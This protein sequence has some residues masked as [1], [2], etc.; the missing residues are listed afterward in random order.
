MLYL[1]GMVVGISGNVVIQST[2]TA[3]DPLASVSASTMLLAVAAIVWLATV[4]GDVAHGVVMFPVLRA[5]QRAQRRRLPGRPDRRRHV[6][7]AVMTLL[8]VMQIPIGA[9]VPRRRPSR[10]CPTSRPSAPSSREANLYAYEFAM[11]AVG[12]AGLILCSAFLRTGL[13]PRPLAIWGLAGYAIILVGSV[14]RSS[15]SSCT[16]STPCRADC[17]RS[18]SACG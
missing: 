1:A 16:R 14:L 9:G 12:V 13:I 6:L 18:S 2:L 8:I 7:I 5:A 15:D 3:P 11:I 10:R 17:G 4:V